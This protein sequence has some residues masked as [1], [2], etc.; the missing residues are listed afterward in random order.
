MSSGP[1]WRRAWIGLPA[2]TL[3]LL[4]CLIIGWNEPQQALLSYLAAFLFFTGL[5]VGSLALLLIHVLTGGVWGIRL[6]PPLLAAA[7]SLP[8]QALLALPILIGLHELY[9]W[10]RSGVSAERVMLAAQSWYLNPEFF[11]ART[12]IYFLLWL[13][14][15]AALGRALRGTQGKA[16]PR[17]A[18]A[19]LIIYAFSTLLAATDW[20]MSLMPQW[21]S[22]TFGML[23]A[24]GWMLAAAALAVLQVARAGNANSV[25]APDILRDLGNL[26]LVLVLAWS[27]LAFMQYL[28][29]WVA[30]QPAETSWYVPRTLTSWRWLA[31]FIIVF[32][33]AVPFALLL[34]RQAKRRRRWLQAIATMLLV[35][36]LADALWLV[37]PDFRLQGF[38]LNWTDLLAVAGMGVLWCSAYLSNL[39]VAAAISSAHAP[40]SAGLLHG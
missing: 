10:A 29:I 24:T 16:L 32:L 17:L 7:R 39:R 25:P 26:L 19:G 20:A 37:L 35:A 12:V 36:N 1:R 33:F 9:P 11:V 13:V 2:G 5:S 30:D 40:G 23:L 8:L 4:L 28:S 18:A 15:L 14:L 22:S 3:L 27:Y 34:S 38:S 31:W 6:R 21:H